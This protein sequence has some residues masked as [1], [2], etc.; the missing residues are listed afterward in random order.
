MKRIHIV[1]PPRSG[2]TLMLELVTT[3][4][5]I[6]IYSKEEFCISVVP[7]PDNPNAIVCTKMPNE[8]W[9]IAELV[10]LDPGQWFIAMIRDPRDVVVS[11]HGLAPD[12]YWANLRQWNACWN[13]VRPYR[14]HE[15]VCLVKYEDLVSRPNETQQEL[16]GKMPFLLRKL[17][18][19]EFHYHS[20][21]SNQSLKA[22]GGLRMMTSK[23]VGVW[24]DHKPRLAGQLE[25][26]GP[27]T[28][29]LVELGY[30]PDE[31]WMET[32]RGVEADKTPGRWPDEWEGEDVRK[33]RDL[34]RANLAE[35]KRIR[36]FA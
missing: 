29:A 27:V 13:N 9:T 11:R 30:E 2:T 6:D 12:R 10:D 35:Y 8:H 4:F 24:R 7:K 31:Q 28:E 34:Q 16:L 23:S 26:H 17:I 22:M 33:W 14:D 20:R 21:P 32:L 18:F 15:R 25:I 3:C 36:G 1:G 19:S 5:H